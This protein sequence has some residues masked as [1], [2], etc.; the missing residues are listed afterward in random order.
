M[1]DDNVE[2]TT[3]AVEFSTYAP[4]APVGVAMEGDV[5]FT[6]LG[7][8]YRVTDFGAYASSATVRLEVST[9]EDFSTLASVS[10]EE[11]VT[12]HWET[13]LSVSGLSPDTYYYRRVRIVNDWNVTT[14]VAVPYTSTRAVPFAAAGPSWAAGDGMVDISLAVSAVYD[15]VTCTAVL[16]YG[17]E[18]VGT[19]TFDAADTVTWSDVPALADGTVATIVV[20][21]TVDGTDFSRTFSAPVTAGAG[22]TAITSVT[23]YCT[24]GDNALWMRPGDV[25]MLPDLY[26]GASYQVLNERFASVS[27]AALTALEPGIVGIRCV[28]ASF[29]TNVMGVVILPDAVGSGS[30]YVFKESKRNNTYDWARSECWDK[31]ENGAR[32]ASN[33]SYPQNADDIAIL[34][35][36][37]V[38]G[39][40]YVRHRTDISIGGLYSGMIRPDASANLVLERYKDD[41]TKTV[42][43]ERTDGEPVQ[44]VV[45][46]NNDTS[47]YYSRIRLGGFTIDVVWAS[48]AVIDCCS[49][50]TDYANGPRGFFDVKEMSS[51]NISTNTLQGVTLTFKGYPG[52]NNSLSSLYGF[53]KGTGTIVKEG[54]GGI[55]FQNDIGGLSGNIVLKGQKTPGGLSTPTTQF[56]IRGGGATN[57]AATVYGVVALGGN[58]QPTSNNGAGLFGTSSQ[59][60]AAP[61]TT[62]AANTYNGVS[63]SRGPDAPAKGLSLVGGSWYAGRVDNKTW[64]VN[65]EDDKQLDFLGVGA[66]MSYIYFQPRNNNTDGYPINVVTAKEL[67]QT[68]RGT[69]A[70]SEPSRYKASTETPGSKFYAEDWEDHATGAAGACESETVHKVI[71]WIVASVNDGNWGN[72]AFA[73]FDANGRLVQEARENVQITEAS[74][75]DA[76]LYVTSRNLNYG[77]AGGDYTINSLYISNGSNNKYL[78]EGRTLRI[79]SGGLI[80]QGA[81]AIGLPG[82][83]DNGS[84][85]LGDA[86]HPAYVWAKA[87]GNNTNYLGAAVTAPGGFVSAYLGNLALVGDQTGIADEIAVNAGTLSIG[88]GAA[89]CTLAE[90]LPIR[91]CAGATLVLPTAAKAV[92]KNPIKLDSHGR[93]FAKVVL[94]V[95]QTCASLAVR[96]VSGG[97]EWTPLPDGTY[98]SSASAAEFIDDDRFAGPGILTVGAAETARS[99][100]LL[101][102]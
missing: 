20:T 83:E 60:G 29:S 3:D 26:G 35:F 96:D 42:T 69:L 57:L 74:S 65:A 19:Q 78:G 93:N 49:S 32:A 38:G 87:Y 89:D 82:R 7:A 14:Y 55:A 51:P 58:G 100:M 56:S 50:E 52:Y 9:Q 92:A 63:G 30:V 36:N 4:G 44:I 34:P 18:E 37:N 1:N 16:T 84:L 46:P 59:V 23:P 76:N 81:S 67:R 2:L 66:G 39:D 91:V 27:G 94:P 43:F 101:V 54:M 12:L 71:P 8:R 15:G 80:L 13:P 33:S 79:K 73:T 21:A 45:C 90:G 25:A 75:E 48:D 97:S 31:V 6:T 47:S 5:G 17:G 62:V 41:T 10:A 70:M 28:D 64:G 102:W 68:E 95:N 24:Y 77:T 40:I 98:G 99:T 53:W 85:V 86:T 61:P 11:A 72:C 88:T 22:A